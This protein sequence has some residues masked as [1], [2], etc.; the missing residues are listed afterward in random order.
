M[1]KLPH[2]RK[3]ANTALLNTALRAGA[4]RIFRAAQ[5]NSAKQGPHLRV[6]RQAILVDQVFELIKLH[7]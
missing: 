1:V 6:P 7:E 3:L 2:F 4:P 5:L